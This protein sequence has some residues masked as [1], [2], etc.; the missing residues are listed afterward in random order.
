M[1]FA[2]KTNTKCCTINGNT[3]T[4]ISLSDTQIEPFSATANLLSKTKRSK[5]SI[6]GK[7]VSKKFT[8]NVRTG[9][10]KQEINREW[11]I[12][13]KADNKKSNKL[14]LR[15]EIESFNVSWIFWFFSLTSWIF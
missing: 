15:Q 12:N 14:I 9:Y 8:G 4:G 2:D 1:S 10:T 6:Y 13:P 7:K 5:F 11:D 3:R